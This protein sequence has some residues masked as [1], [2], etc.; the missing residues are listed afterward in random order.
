MVETKYYRPVT[1]VNMFNSLT[2]QLPKKIKK[3]NYIPGWSNHTEN[4]LKSR[5]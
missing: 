5:S 2:Y 4:I 1:M 3:K